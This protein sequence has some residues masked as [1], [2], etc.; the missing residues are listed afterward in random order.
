VIQIIMCSG[1]TPLSSR[2]FKLSVLPN[3]SE[4]ISGVTLDTR[5]NCPGELG[6]PPLSSKSLKLFSDLVE[7]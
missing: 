1:L 7:A 2:I 3:K 4:D 6:S 5:P